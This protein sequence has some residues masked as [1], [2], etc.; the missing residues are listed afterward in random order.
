MLN[1]AAWAVL[2]G[3]T[4]SEKLARIGIVP[5]SA[6]DIRKL[7]NIEENYGV[8]IY[9]FFEEV[10]ARE[11]TL[12]AVLD[13]YEKVPEYE[14][15]VIRVSSFLSFTQENDP[16]FEQT[17]GEFPLMV[18]IVAIGGTADEPYVTGLMPF[19]DEL[20]MDAAPP[21]PGLHPFPEGGPRAG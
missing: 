21:E 11:K 10:L 13:A 6:V 20:D 14:R 17:L 4:P 5:G 1:K 9:L 3:T 2:P 8:P 12:A 19:L 16:S 18:T 15:P 7:G